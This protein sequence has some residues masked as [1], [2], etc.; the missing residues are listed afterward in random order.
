M[1]DGE[2]DHTWDDVDS[3]PFCIHWGDPADCAVLCVCGHPCHEHWGGNECHNENCK[4]K[5]FADSDENKASR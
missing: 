1:C 4:C 2:T 5:E 3:G